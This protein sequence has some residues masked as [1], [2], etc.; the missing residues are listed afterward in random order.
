MV[1]QTL[2]P[3][4]MKDTKHLMYIFSILLHFTCIV[5]TYIITSVTRSYMY[6]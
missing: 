1:L 5:I 6:N 3:L 2:K 4:Q